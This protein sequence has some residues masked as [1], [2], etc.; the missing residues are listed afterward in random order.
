MLVCILDGV[1]YTVVII[2]ML[3]LV[4]K[5]C[6]KFGITT[7]QKRY[8]IFISEYTETYGCSMYRG[9]TVVVCIGGVRLLYISGVYDCCI[10]R[11]CSIVVCIGDVRLWYVSGV[12]DCV[13]HRGCT[14]VVCI[15]G[16][17]LW[18]ISGVYSCGMYRECRV[19]K[20]CIKIKTFWTALFLK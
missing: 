1:L 5:T 17:Q 3:I 10:Y 18:Y 8:C 11:G 7:T 14:V 19:Y 13:M 2:L 12:Y 9:C 20:S 6:K 15:G 4:K 16:V